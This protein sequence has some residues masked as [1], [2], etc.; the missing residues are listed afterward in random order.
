MG[1]VLVGMASV[2]VAL[3]FGPPAMPTTGIGPNCASDVRQTLHSVC[4]AA[5][6]KALSALRF[7][8]L[9][10]ISGVLRVRKNLAVASRTC[11]ASAAQGAGEAQR[12]RSFALLE[13][14]AGNGELTLKEVRAAA[15]EL[16]ALPGELSTLDMM[17]ALGACFVSADVSVEGMELADVWSLVKEFEA[18]GVKPNTMTCT[19]MMGVCVHFAAAGRAG[20]K[21]ALAILDWTRASSLQLDHVLLAQVMDVC[22]KAAM[23]G[24]SETLQVLREVLEYGRNLDPPVKNNVVTYTSMLD[25]LAKAILCS[26]ASLDDVDAAWGMM[27]ADGVLP[28]CR[29]YSAMLTACANAA[30]VRRRPT[31]QAA[32]SKW[33]SSCLLSLNGA[34]LACSAFW[35]RLPPCLL[36]SRACRGNKCF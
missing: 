28:N 4:P 19:H 15:Q 30:V 18:R 25:A 29:S 22:A 6:S 33:C 11:L 10:T 36:A 31:A 9:S 24:G 3:A 5:S 7:S 2:N 34:P 21:E 8:G 1:V 13:I 35:P 14:A 23:H 20:Q 12:F 17:A 27:L 32:W 16:V 26:K